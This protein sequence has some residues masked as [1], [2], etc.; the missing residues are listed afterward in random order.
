MFI[1]IVTAIH[2]HYF[3]VHIKVIHIETCLTFTP[4]PLV[5]VQRQCK[6]EEL[7]SR[8]E[9]VEKKCRTTEELVQKAQVGRESNVSQ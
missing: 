4:G 6:L 7:G 2:I 3:V 5:S 1:S 8:L 9:Q